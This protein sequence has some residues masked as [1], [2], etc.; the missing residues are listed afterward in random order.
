MLGL[1]VPLQRNLGSLGFMGFG[2]RVEGVKG[3]ECTGL[4][5]LGSGIMGLASAS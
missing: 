2:L 4:G 3:L 1:D 5:F